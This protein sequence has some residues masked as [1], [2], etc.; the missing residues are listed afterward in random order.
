MILLSFR[1][2][3]NLLWGFQI[4]FVL[5]LVLPVAALHI[6]S[7]QKR[8]YLETTVALLAGIIGSFS[9]SQGLFLWPCALIL[10]VMPGERSKRELLIWSCAG[11]L[12]WIYYF[13]GYTKPSHHPSLQFIIE[14]PFEGFRFFCSILG[15]L[16]AW[17]E[18]VSFASGFVFLV[19]F[20]AAVVAIIKHRLFEF[21]FWLVLGIFS[22]MVVF[23]ITVGRAGTSLDVAFS[24]RYTTFSATFLV[25]VIALL[26]GLSSSVTTTIFRFI[27]VPLAIVLIVAVP[28]S[29]LQG[30][31]SGK[32]MH[33]GFSRMGFLLRN[34]RM[35]PAEAMQYL[36]IP[37]PSVVK[38][39]API[40]ESIGHEIFKK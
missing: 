17:R 35:V 20:I 29:Y 7:S 32:F 19:A 27:L 9:S 16:V 18:D 12:V 3:E 26:S 31:N 36:Y 38:E 28:F 24:S 1:Q 33:N 4:G 37:N 40:L 34:Y 21:R 10:L 15:N 13:Y 8:G 23:G 11:G 2:S 25:S 22:L 14:H 30:W 5:S 39:R 6:L